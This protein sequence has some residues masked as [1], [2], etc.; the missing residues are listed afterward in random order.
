MIPAV[1]TCYS[2]NM[3]EVAALTV[4]THAKFAETWSMH[5]E[6]RTVPQ[7]GCLW[8]KVAMI[9]EYLERGHRLVC[10]LDADA[11]VTNPDKKPPK[12]TGVALTCDV[13]GPN[14]GIMFIANTLLTRQFFFALSGYGRQLVANLINPE[15]TAIRWLT[16]HPPYD[17]LL[18]CHSQRTM[19]SY[20]PGAYEYPGA[21]EADWQ[22]GDMILHLPALSDEQRVEILKSI[23]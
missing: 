17:R 22:Q 1:I 2:E 20:W 3:A 18:E 8:A 14:A 9:R 10:W 4:P 23:L 19:N 6:A 15:Q 13:H 7:E 21:S 16:M 12:T 11:A 5:H